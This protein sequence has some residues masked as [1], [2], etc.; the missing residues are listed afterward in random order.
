MGMAKQII[1]EIATQAHKDADAWEAAGKGS[2]IEQVYINDANDVRVIIAQLER[3]NNLDDF[4]GELYNL[5][6]IVRETMY[7]T[8]MLAEKW[9]KELE[10][11]IFY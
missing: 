10:T 7:D 3:W 2:N 8:I 5:D 1:T 9:S 11:G 6:T 4:I